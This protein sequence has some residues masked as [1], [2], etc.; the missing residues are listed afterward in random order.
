[1]NED[2]NLYLNTYEENLI[3]MSY[4][5]CIGGHS[6]ASIWHAHDI[7]ENSYRRIKP[8]S[9]DFMAY[10][11]RCEINKHINIG[12]ASF[13]LDYSVPRDKFYPMELFFDC[14]EKNN[15]NNINEFKNINEIIGHWDDN[16]K[17]VIYNI[18]YKKDNSIGDYYIS[19]LLEL[20]HWANLASFLDKKCHKKCK[21]AYKDKSYY[22]EYFESFNI[23]NYNYIDNILL[24]KKVKMPIDDYLK[25][26]REHCGLIDDNIVED[27]ISINN[28][29][30]ITASDI[31]DK[32][33]YYML[34]NELRCISLSNYYKNKKLNED[35][36]IVHSIKID[37][38][39][40][41][42]ALFYYKKNGL[43]GCG[44]EIPAPTVEIINNIY[45][46]FLNIINEL[47]NIDSK[48]KRN[49]LVKLSR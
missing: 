6:M 7:A 22:C 29:E 2:L 19:Y 1:M 35:D 10:D 30:Y 38:N 46:D 44:D 34:R 9:R 49:I 11:I 31:K 15:L 5:Y 37:L 24:F 41:D 16:K 25:F 47:K 45:N 12:G 39:K 4:K 18:S 3:W 42:I 32:I 8:E 14:I 48:E 13:R 20:I 33:R 43:E 27:N 21:V 26:N 23:I 40:N 28:E 36:K 17:E